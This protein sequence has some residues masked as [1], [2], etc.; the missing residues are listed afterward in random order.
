MSKEGHQ[1]AIKVHVAAFGK[2]PGWDDHIEEIGLDCDALV[3]VKRA[4]YT[5]GIAG[6]ID[7]G[8]WEKLSE[9]HRL[10]GFRHV[11]YWRRP[12]GFV[13]GRMWSSRDGRGRTKYPMVVVAMIEGVPAPWTIE[14]ALPRLEA[15]ESKV[16]QTAAAELVRLA[17]GEARRGLEDEAA[18]LV[19]GA[20]STNIP[21]PAA[22]LKALVAS[23][24][25][26]LP[27]DDGKGMGLTRIMYEMERE[28]GAFRSSGGGTRGLTRM[29]AEVGG[30]HLRVPRCLAPKGEAACAWIEAMSQ[31]I[32]ES[33]P[34]LVVEPLDEDFL[35]IIVGD[36]RPSALFCV[37][38]S[39][40]GLALTSDVPYTIEPAF[41]Q[42]A[43]ERQAAWAAGKLKAMPA[44]PAA[45]ALQAVTEVGN[46]KGMLI[47]IG[48]GALL[49]LV[50]LM[51]AFSGGSKPPVAPEPHSDATP[52]GDK[53]PATK[54]A[55]V[56]EQKPAPVAK[57]EPAPTQASQTSQLEPA[58]VAAPAYAAGDIRAGWGFDAAMAAVRAKLD[59]LET[60][61]KIE[62]KTPDAA[63]REA[64]SR[65][66]ERA[67]K[68]V[69]GVTLTPT[70]Q[71]SVRRDME[72]CEQMLAQAAK[73]I[74]T[75][76]DQVSERVA[77]ELKAKADQPSVTTEA[78]KKAWRQA[79]S[80]VDPKL[81]YQQA[82][83]RVAAITTG[84][85]DAEGRITQ[86]AGYKPPALPDADAGAI[87]A[88]NA[89]RRDAALQ[90]AAD[91]IA[92]GDLDRH[93]K[94]IEMYLADQAAAQRELELARRLE[95]L[96]AL[97]EQ[98]GESAT[99]S[100]MVTELQAS[101]AWKELGSALAGVTARVRDIGAL[102][103]EQSPD[104]L[105]EVIHQGTADV[106]RLRAGEV[107][108]AWLQLARVGWPKTASDLPLAGKTLADEVRKTLERISDEK[109]RA[110]AIAR[111]NDAAGR[112]WTGFVESAGVDA[113]GVGAAIDS[114]SLLGVGP[115]AI[116]ALPGWAR[117]NIARLKLE[118]A[119]TQ[120]ATKQGGARADAQAAAMNE[121]VQALQGA[122]VASA[123]APAALLAAIEPLR[124]KGAQ[125]DLSKL[126][127]G[128]AGWK[129]SQSDDGQTA[130]Y[131]WAKN[132]NEHKL[133]FRRL[134]EGS[135][136]EV[137][138]I[139]TTEM[140]VGE[141]ADIVSAQ[142][143]WEEFKDL[144]AKSSEGGV[145]PR[146]GPRSWSWAGETPL[147][148][149]PSKPA[150]PGDLSGGWV[151]I[152][153]TMQ[154]K[155]YYPDGIT[156]P[157]PAT[158]S[159]MQHVGPIPALLA[160]RMVGC[161]FPSVEEWKRALAGDGPTPAPNLRDATWKKE[162]DYIKQFAA[163]S[164]QWPASGIFAAPGQA[165]VSA[166]QDD[167]PAVATDDGVLWF[168]PV[169]AST[170][171]TF[172]DLLGN[173]SEFVIE[174]PAAVENIQ[175]TREGVEAALGKG[176]KLK[177]IGGSALSPQTQP[178]SEPQPVSFSQARL[179][180]SD[181][182][183]RLAFSAPRAAGAAGVGE[184]LEAALGANGYLPAQK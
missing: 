17:I 175:P 71:D 182:G 153:S 41:R 59:R 97:G 122:E 14:H 65:A 36:V 184:R 11:F 24:A 158:T 140:S 102:A 64:L 16:S 95:D 77:A 91:A 84:L 151:R 32:S 180:Y 167:Q 19:A 130:T 58:K 80:S 76:L 70:N 119:V 62:H 98:P 4:L 88:I 147:G 79:V 112:M 63:L 21:P 172:H 159:P 137:S 37:R 12:D 177:I 125:L 163:F 138:F 136:G 69:K 96:I 155:K 141:F 100:A 46:N 113:K 143:K 148:I 50:V 8:A 54:P 56:A 82:R 23:P 99:M 118:R 123:G 86:A 104:K 83:E 22:L 126:G 166:P 40:K 2:H 45:G 154:Q 162:Y 15:I 145:D 78:M 33:V 105:L 161:R 168:R 20:P 13:V 111:A 169:D 165:R 30:Q 128:S 107:L 150:G 18:L 135:G 81:G 3:Q 157:P 27:S 174:D 49:L 114:M 110:S 6:N 67:T 124:S 43:D 109:A 60:E 181:V 35:D 1:R 142:G 179:G 121:F 132:G 146:L 176:E 173:V 127:P 10:P 39:A 152:S 106:T 92:Q 89:S 90:A 61:L 103:D 93:R 55:E 139:A 129:L 57:P 7:S 116:D 28:M 51:Y 133:S 108:G 160:A 74:D 171:G 29:Q 38:A 5:E 101:P 115:R 66:E 183:F 156:V 120:A 34:V 170:P 68:F 87:D 47:A 44:T 9:D 85:V 117:Y 131:S 72:A 149:Q 42:A 26:S 178:T 25:L 53:P 31:S 94:V 164:P 144:L 52:A 134:A 75:Q 73:D 48:V